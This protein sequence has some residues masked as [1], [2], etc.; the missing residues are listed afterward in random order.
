VAGIEWVRGHIKQHGLESQC[1]WE[2]E[3]EVFLFGNDLKET[4]RQRVTLPMV[5][6]GQQAEVTTS[7]VPGRTP[8][9]SAL[10]P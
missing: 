2:A 10:Q 3:K 8:M 5:I 6:S 7:T 9:L 1:R 4:S